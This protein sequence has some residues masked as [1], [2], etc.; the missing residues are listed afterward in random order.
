MALRVWLPLTGTLENKGIGMP[1][2]TTATPSYTTG[3]IGQC[4]NGTDLT[5]TYGDYF[6]KIWSIC[7][8]G[9]V[10]GNQITSNWTLIA[11][12]NDGGS[13]LRIEVCPSSYN[14]GIFCYSTHNNANYNITT[15]GINSPNGGYYDQW[16]HFCLTSDGTTITKYMN[17]IKIGTCA[18]NGNGKIN[19]TFLLANNNKIYK[20]DFR[21]YD[22]CLSAAEVK[23][24]SQ[25]L[26]LHYKL[27]SLNNN[28]FKLI[29]QGYHPTD[30]CGYNLGLETNLVRGQQ[31]T[32]Q[33]WDVTIS[34]SRKTNTQLNL[35]L[36]WGG[37]NNWLVTLANSNFTN[38]HADYLKAT[39]TAPASPSNATEA[40]NAWINVYNSPS[41]ASGT[42]NMH[43]GAWKIEKG[44]IGTQWSGN[45]NMI[46]DSSGYNHNGTITGA[47]TLTSDT[48]RYSVAITSNAAASI[49]N[50]NSTIPTSLTTNNKYTMCA[51]LKTNAT[52]NRWI[53]SI[54]H[55][56]GGYRGLWLTTNGS[57]PHFAYSG[58]GAFTATTTVNDNIWH[59]IAFTVDGATSKCFVDGVQCGSSTST[60]TDVAGNNNITVTF[61]GS[62]SIS[63]F[64]IYCTALS[65]D[66]ILTLYHTGAKIDNRQNFHTY[67]LVEN[68]SAIK[69]TKQGQTKLNE[70]NEAT[71]TKFYKTNKIIKTKQAIEF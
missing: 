68:Q 32:V 17:G 2:I 8:W 66:D 28:L 38:G 1:T 70:L 33:F 4:Y 57:K 13:N 3:K 14:N 45:D 60:K 29:P 21:I 61:N 65:A 16:V 23:E 49:L 5:I 40:Q 46:I 69:I 27:D 26:V 52:N 51:W 36:Y 10:V 7:F 42:L 24:I 50:S 11:R 48:P 41:Y 58:S 63:D 56:T 39:F 22:H 67:E 34:H 37:G 59:H 43:I 55:G 25:G 53:Y 6:N 20:N 31:Y 19:G 18:Y 62:D 12:L 9:Y 35:Q 15:G 54:G 30:Y 44:S 47:L 71:T 64:R